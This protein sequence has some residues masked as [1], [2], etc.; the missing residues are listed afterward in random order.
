MYAYY[1]PQTPDDSSM[2]FVSGVALATQLPQLSD[3]NSRQ[4]LSTSFRFLI[5]VSIPEPSLSLPPPNPIQHRR[6]RQ[7]AHQPQS[8]LSVTSHSLPSKL[9][10]VPDETCRVPYTITS[11]DIKIKQKKT[12]GLREAGWLLTA[13]EQ[14]QPRHPWELSRNFPRALQLPSSSHRIPTLAKQGSQGVILQRGDAEVRNLA[15]G[16]RKDLGG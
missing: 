8:T 15:L 2:L 12:R 3:G 5:E 16:T 14:P 13:A 6:C 1:P 9:P 10:R 11:Y 4:N 7:V